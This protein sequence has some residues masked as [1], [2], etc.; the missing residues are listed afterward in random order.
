MASSSSSSSSNA[1]SEVSNKLQLIKQLLLGESSPV[2][3][4]YPGGFLS[5][6]EAYWADGAG[7]EPELGYS[8]SDSVRTQNSSSHSTIAVSELDC[9]PDSDIF[10]FDMS[11]VPI[12][13]PADLFEFEAKPQIIDLTAPE[14]F[15]SFSS[16]RDSSGFFEFE[17]KPLVSTA[18]SSL[19]GGS[20]QA[21]RKP[22]L[23]IS[24]PNK[25]EWLQFGNGDRAPSAEVEAPAL[26]EDHRHYRGVRQRPWGKYAA[27]IRDP[28]RKGSR[29]W[30]GTYDTAI[31]AARAY[32]RAA[33]RLRGSK[34]ILNFPLEAGKS[35]PMAS[36][37]HKKRRREEEAE[38]VA[39]REKLAAPQSGGYRAEAPSNWTSFLEG[40]V[41]GMFNVP[42]LSPLSPHP[43]LGFPQLTVI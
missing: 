27:E 2:A 13:N 40:E 1:S 35:E 9:F 41:K 15:S 31:E 34:A 7:K 18:S 20:S 25:V 38:A 22:S 3:T 30:L 36:R 23:K 32:D 11:S 33:F 14:S 10:N 42:P 24:L 19:Q 4:A 16:N 6:A 12:H 43:P 37:D 5:C 26:E 17:S 8:R 39:K 28:N 29:V 21:S